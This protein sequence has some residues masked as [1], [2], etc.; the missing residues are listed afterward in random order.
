VF[1]YVWTPNNITVD[2]SCPLSTSIVVHSVVLKSI[3]YQALIASWNIAPLQTL[4]Y[5]IER[6]PEPEHHHVEYTTNQYIFSRYR[7]REFIAKTERTTRSYLQ[8]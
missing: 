3:A 4:A 7:K 6:P 8:Q 2:A 5:Q 1:S